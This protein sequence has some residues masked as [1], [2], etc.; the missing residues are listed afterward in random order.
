MTTTTAPSWLQG[1][2]PGTKDHQW[3]KG[4]SGNYRGR[5]KGTPNKK[6]QIS[7]A[8]MDDGAAIARVV[9]DAAL[10][11]DMTAANIVL[12]RIQPVLRARAER[13]QFDLDPNGPLTQ[14]AQQILCAVSVGDIDPETG[15]LLIDSISSFS[16]LKE[17]DELA[18]R[19]GS[20]EAVLNRQSEN[21]ALAAAEI[22]MLEARGANGH[23]PS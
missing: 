11:G 21:A 12:S 20:V 15:K 18:A 6:T 8:L 5:P 10:G 14:Q 4:Q 19:L 22:A 2:Q 9:I 17:V 23:Y 7:E 16:K 3:K 13:V 1:H